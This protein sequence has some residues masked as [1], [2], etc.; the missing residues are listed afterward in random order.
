MKGVK[1]IFLFGTLLLFIILFFVYIETGYAAQDIANMSTSVSV[2]S[3][4]SMG[5]SPASLDFSSVDPGTTTAKK[6]I[7]VWCSTNGNV[8]WVLQ[9]SDTAELTSGAYTVPNENFHWWGWPSGRGTWYHGTGALSTTPF[10][11]YECDLDEYITAAPVEVHLSFNIEVPA[12]QAA[13]AYT[14]TLIITMIEQ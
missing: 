7:D 6:D 10:T 1:K 2:N 5:V 8:A 3:V 4:F 9:I 13:G 11:F 14:S 12:T